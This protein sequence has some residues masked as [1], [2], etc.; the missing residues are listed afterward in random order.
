MEISRIK[1]DPEIMSYVDPER[2]YVFLK[3]LEKRSADLSHNIAAG[4][5]V[6]PPL[7]VRNEDTRLLDGYC[8]Y[9]ALKG[10]KV[11]KTYTYVDSP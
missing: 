3:S 7:I 5:V 4:A 1:L 9:A 2:G 11:S 10:M 8:R 6:L